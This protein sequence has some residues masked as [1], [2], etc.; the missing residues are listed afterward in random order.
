MTRCLQDLVQP[1]KPQA[2]EFHARAQ[3]EPTRRDLLYQTVLH[4]TLHNCLG[5]VALGDCEDVI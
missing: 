2:A 3:S 4:A 5:K 1:L